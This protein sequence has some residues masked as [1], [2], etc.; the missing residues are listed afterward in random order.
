MRRQIVT[1]D[2]EN[3][4]KNVLCK[5][6]KHFITCGAILILRARVQQQQVLTG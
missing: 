5:D 6:I 4:I 3:A 2:K 1:I